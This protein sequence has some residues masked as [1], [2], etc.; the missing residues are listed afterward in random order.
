MN[1]VR[2]PLY[3]MAIWCLVT[4]HIA[5]PFP[6]LAAKSAAASKEKP[7]KK[8]SPA[9]DMKSYMESHKVLSDTLKKTKT[10]LEAEKKRSPASAGMAN[11]FLSEVDQAK[12]LAENSFD[13]IFL[14]F[15]HFLKADKVSN[16]LA[17]YIGNRLKH[18]SHSLED[19]QTALT[20]NIGKSPYAGNKLFVDL[21][22]QLAG[23]QVT[24]A[25]VSSRIIP[26][27]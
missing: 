22:A 20:A 23:Y 2:L 4:L 21:Q 26:V 5:S 18:L 13:L 1:P 14:Y 25:E 8:T 24:I 10:F 15:D 7:D 6:A 27:Q 17:G 12:A 16:I 9:F 19:M 3:L 11:Y